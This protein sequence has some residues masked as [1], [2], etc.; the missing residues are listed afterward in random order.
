QE[1]NV[2]GVAGTDALDQ[3]TIFSN[4]GFSCVDIAAPGVSFMGLTV[5]NPYKL[6]KN[7]LFDQ[8]YQGYWD[9]T[10]MSTAV[11]SGSLALLKS[12][13]PE[14]KRAELINFLLNT[15][16]NVNALNPKYPDQLGHGRINLASAASAVYEDLMSYRKWVIIAPQNN[17]NNNIIRVFNGE[18]NTAPVFFKPFAD[19]FGGGVSVSA[20]DTNGDGLEEIVASAGTQVKIF[21]GSGKLKNQFSIYQKNW[22]GY[23]NVAAGDTNGDGTAE[24]IV[25]LSK[26]NEP[27]IRIFNDHGILQSQFFAYNKNFR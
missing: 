14:I 20:G 5:V 16:D 21:D 25:G 19:N 1:H 9:G 3:K 15:A 11:V 2:I 17:I 4:Y 7:R 6:Y 13:N 23:L 24:I 18:S 27:K 22:R 8:Y 10:S 12:I 26:N